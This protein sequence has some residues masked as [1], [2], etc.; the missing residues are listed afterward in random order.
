MLSLAVAAA[1]VVFLFLLVRRAPRA[2]EF[3]AFDLLPLAGLALAM[4]LAIVWLI[5][6]DDARLRPCRLGN[7]AACETVATKLLESAERAPSAPPTGWEERAAKV[8]TERGCRGPESGPCAV[9]LYALGS[10]AGRA[11]RFDAAKD[12]FLRACDMQPSWCARAAQEK[13]L[14]WTP[15]ERERLEPSRRGRR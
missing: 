11:G 8:L 7:D 3:G 10:V 15:A 12:A 6:G 5:G 1:A 9:R 2:S 4:T 13:A 14:E